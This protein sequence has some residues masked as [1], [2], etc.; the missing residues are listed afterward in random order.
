MNNL[1]RPTIGFAFSGASSRSIFYIGFL[2][3]LSE[4]GFPIDYISAMSGGAVVAASYACGTLPELKK[5]AVSLDKELIFNFIE[6]SRGRGGLYHLN[7][8]ESLLRVYTQ[9]KRF[10][11][12]STRLG[13]VA[14]DLTSE[15][16]VVLQMGDIARAVTASCTLPGIFQ[17]LEWG[18]KQLVDGGLIN[19]VP[20]NVARDANIDIVVGI[21]MRAT[22]HIF[23]AWQINLKKVLNKFKQL[24][25]PSQFE[26]LWQ[27]LSNFLDYPDVY[28]EYATV[29]PNP[30]LFSV[31]GKSMDIAIKAQNKHNDEKFN[32]DLLI[33]PESSNL[34][35]WK[36]YLFLHFTDFSN[37]Q[38]Y[39]K[40]GRQTAK[41]YLP[42]L[43]QMLA[44]KEAELSKA[45]DR[46]EKLFQTK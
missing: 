27:K 18:N 15:D 35:M 40:S 9:N 14:T 5:L 31:L 24:L 38:E 30:N 13:I 46:V 45:T 16:E 2:E 7:K 34:P 39:Y 28:S 33:V 11:D 29:Q 4:N 36:R 8:V 17:P 42:Q 43:W 20:G 41:K 21:D 19:I 3:V 23:S 10:E 22:R 32:C 6:R 26:L 12:V 25:W 1:G 44:E 37:T